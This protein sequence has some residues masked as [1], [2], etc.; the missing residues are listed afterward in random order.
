MWSSL[1]LFSFQLPALIVYLTGAAPV[2]GAV[3]F[4]F[5]QGPV[6]A[7]LGGVTEGKSS[8]PAPLSRQSLFTALA[9]VDAVGILVFLGGLH[10]LWQRA[11]T[12]INDSDL[13]L[14][15]ASD[16]SVLLRDIPPGVTVES[17]KHYLESFSGKELLSGR[18]MEVVR[19]VLHFSC[20][21]LIT[22][23]T[24]RGALFQ[25]WSLGE[26]GRCWTAAATAADSPFLTHS[27]GPHRAQ[28]GAGDGARGVL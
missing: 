10:V 28:L 27:G 25:E 5:D 2:D 26:T 7:S 6:S 4:L 11:S 22:D 16:Y 20:A 12:E 8:W 1:L 13:V 21:D 17:I 9:W 14:T 23:L 15:T 3:S 18:P 24:K 19:V